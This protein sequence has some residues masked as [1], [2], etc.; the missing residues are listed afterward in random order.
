MGKTSFNCPY[1]LQC[2]TLKSNHTSCKVFCNDM[3]KEAEKLFPKIWDKTTQ[4]YLDKVNKINS[5]NYK[6]GDFTSLF[7]KTF[8]EVRNALLLEIYNN[9]TI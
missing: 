8:Y 5:E 9:G 2:L 3:Q 1:E 4:L 7:W 6:Q